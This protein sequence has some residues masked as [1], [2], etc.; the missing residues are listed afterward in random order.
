MKTLQSNNK[1]LTTGWIVLIACMLIQAIPFGVASNIKPLFI[2]PVTLDKGF[3][4]GSFSLIFTIG[5]IVSA[6][7]SPF[8]GKLY[9]KVNLKIMYII[10]CVLAGGGFM[11]F[12][13]CEELWQFYLVSGVVNIGNCMISAIGVPLLINSWFDGDSKGKALGIAFSG[14]SIGNIFLQQAVVRSIANSGYQ[15]AYFIFGALALV[16][17]LPIALLMLRLPKANENKA[18]MKSKK[19]DKKVKTE[20]ID[21]GYTF[22]EVKKL[23]EFWM[24]AL[25]FVFV[26][27]YVSAYSIQSSPYF[28]GALKLDAAVVATIGSIFAA[29]SLI[30]NILGGLLYDKLGPVKCLMASFIAVLAS[31]VC[32]LMSDKSPTFAYLF[33]AVRGLTVFVYMM[34]PAY[35]VGKFFSGKE[36]GS[37]LGVVS[38]IFAVGFSGGSA[39]LGVLIDKLGYSTSWTIILVAVVMAFIC[40]IAGSIGMTKKNEQRLKQIKIN[41]NLAA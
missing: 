5:T 9:E 31:G 28:Q 20:V 2:H 18:S 7:A 6:I 13:M 30:G 37:I 29:S 15:Q 10:G 39:M 25:G 40:L 4:L 19:A 36:F 3:S 16:V 38:L 41:K 14:G 34:T 27:I 26:G 22:N 24:I 21:L 23:K 8:I 33:S 11:A 1:K 12:S 32:L 17:G 35:L